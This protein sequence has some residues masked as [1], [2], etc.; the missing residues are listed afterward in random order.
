M[1]EAK[2]ALQSNKVRIMQE[3]AFQLR[4]EKYAIEFSAEVVAVDSS[5]DR[6]VVEFRLI[7]GDAWL[8]KELCNRVLPTIRIEKQEDVSE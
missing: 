4:C 6:F 8:Y 1:E 2:R 5:M 3:N 7:H